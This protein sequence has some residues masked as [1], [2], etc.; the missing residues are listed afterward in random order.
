MHN[1]INHDLIEI[2]EEDEISDYCYL[3]EDDANESQF[4]YVINEILSGTARLNVLLPQL[5]SWPSLYLLPS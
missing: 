3:R 5:P 1:L 4:M 2:S